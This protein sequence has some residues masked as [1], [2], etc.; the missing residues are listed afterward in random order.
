VLAGEKC[1]RLLNDKIKELPVRNV[2]ADEI[3]GFIGMK[4][5]TKH[6]N[7]IEDEHLGTCYTWVAMETH[8]KLVLAWHLGNRTSGDCV[9][10]TE[11]INEATRGRFQLSTD[12]FP[13]YADAVCYSLGTR[14]D[15]AQLTK[16]YESGKEAKVTAKRYSPTKF[17]K[18]I[19]TPIWGQPDMEKLCTSHIERLNLSLRMALRRLTR[20]TNAFSKKW[21]NMK[22]ALALYFAYYN[23]VRTHQT[24]RCTPAMAHKITKTFW[25]IEDLLN[26]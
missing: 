14:V 26:Y 13:A 15:Y 3:W 12:A 11:K 18:A 23:F 21:Y 7:K 1:E 17:I 2:Q 24:L 5:R 16:I 4:N 8:T 6:Q 22:C 9:Q 19:P 25:S 10:F 20:L